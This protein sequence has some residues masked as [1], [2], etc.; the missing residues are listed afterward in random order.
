VA[1][2]PGLL[3]PGLRGL[4]A[5]VGSGATAASLRQK[6]PK[7]GWPDWFFVPGSLTH[8]TAERPL[9]PKRVVAG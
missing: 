5:A 9:V 6:F 8:F 3:K 7:A 4:L 2:K 1:A